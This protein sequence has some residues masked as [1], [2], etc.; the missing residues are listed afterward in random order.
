MT[1][2]RNMQRLDQQLVLPLEGESSDRRSFLRL[3]GFGVAAGA[4][5]SCSR[6]PVSKAVPWLTAPEDITAGRAYRMATTCAA[7]PTGCGALVT[8]K[9]GR[10]LKMEGLPG[11]AVSDGALCA[12]GQASVLELY[13]SQRIDGPQRSD[14]PCAWA[15]AD[16]AIANALDTLKSAGRVRILTDTR[17]GPATLATIQSFLARTKDGR[18]VM[19]DALSCS[20]IAA[21]HLATHGLRAMPRIDL[22]KA[23]VLAAFDADFLGTWYSPVEH[24]R[25]WAAARRNKQPDA[26]SRHWHFES[27]MSVTGGVADIRRRL[28]PH[29]LPAAIARLAA[30]VTGGGGIRSELSCEADLVLLAD[31]LRSARGSALVLCGTNDVGV[32]TQVNQINAAL[33]AYGSTLDLGTSSRQRRGDDAAV[34]ELWNELDSGSVDLLIVAGVNPA[35]DFPARASTLSK[36][37]LFV[38]LATNHD[39]TSALAHWTCPEPHFLERWDDHEAQDGVVAIGQPLIQPLMNGRTLRLSLARWS[40]DQSDELAL[41]K[42]SFEANVFSR[43]KDIGSFTRWWRDLLH[44][45]FARV[46]PRGGAHPFQPNGVQAAAARTAPS[47]GEFALVLTPKVG[48]LDGRHAH[49]PWLQ[50]LADPVSR[51]AW[52]CEACLSPAAAA[53]LGVSEG[54]VVR[55][56]AQGMQALRAPVHILPGLHDQVITFP[57]GYGRACTERFA[58]IGPK[59]WEG[60]R[61]LAQGQRLGSNVAAWREIAHVRVER[62][63]EH[64][65][66]ATV[67]DYRSLEVPAHLAPAHGEVRNHVRHASVA[68]LAADPH[69][70]H[71]G[72]HHP[73]AAELWSPDHA[74]SGPRFGLA[75]DLSAC[76]GCS[77]CVIACQAENNVPVVGRDEVRRHREMAWIRIDRYE[78]GTGDDVAVHQ[79]PMMCQ[80]CGHAPCESVCPVLATVHSADGLNQQVYNRCVGTRYCA[81]TCPYKV[82]RFNWFD[83]PHEDALENHALNPDVTVRTRGVMEKCS[84]CVQ[85]IQEARLEVRRLGLAVEDGD[86]QTA[87]QQTCPTQAIVFGNLDDPKSKVAML[88]AGGRSYRVLEELNV[89][90]SVHYLADVRN[91]RA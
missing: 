80:H 59:W 17:T 6:A 67:Q 58:G 87:C 74:N 79:Q 48:I 51:L 21:A 70:A 10:P 8:C 63:G 24:A 18:H 85:R 55:I 42:R 53:R 57:L 9:D 23:K 32:Q 68:A 28:A 37:R 45:G 19:Y 49:N 13:D 14:K 90:P 34:L 50:E 71:A 76:N 35:F 26:H 12:V 3:M 36:A 66:L 31:E 16:V 77:A 1:T 20:A 38:S 60:E 65:E 22:A 83:Y 86:I 89:A 44:N 2:P 33:G 54:D 39:E 11:H 25:G 75:I 7:C 40:G 52:E 64:V 78:S 72:T 73:A 91:P 61:T 47:G 27:S 43:Q 15:D 88:A 46:A 41:L 4:L 84:M 81:N 5:A 69:A 56:E 82:R 62:S 29:E 30:L